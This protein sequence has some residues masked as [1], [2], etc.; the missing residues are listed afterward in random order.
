V[1][2]LVQALFVGLPG[3]AG[4]SEAREAQV[5]DIIVRE[6]A[7][8]LPLRNGIIPSKPPLYH[9]GAAALSL[10]L[11]EVSEFTARYTSQICAVICV[12]LVSL[13][14]YR[15]AQQRRSF[16]SPHHP[17][18][19]A[20]L[21]AAI[22][23]LTYGFYQMGCQA[24]VDMT[25][26]VC[27]WAAL[28]SVALSTRLGV[29]SPQQVSEVGRTL[30]WFCCALGVLARGPLGIA[31]PVALVGMAGWC[32]IGFVTTVR[33]FV[34]PSFGWFALAI[35]VVWYYRAYLVGGDA[36]L[37]RQLFFENIKRFSGGE[38]VNSQPWWFYV[39]SVLRTTLPWGI[40]L[41][42]IVVSSIF[43]QQTLSYPAGIVR[44]RWLP[45]ILLCTGIVLFSLS[46]GKRHSYLLP[47]LPLIAVQLGVEVS[48]LFEGGG[49]RARAR[50]VRVGRTTEVMLAGVSMFILF[51]IGVVGEFF[52]TPAGYL[53]DAYMAI[54]A[55]ISRSAILVVVCAIGT[56]LGLRRRLLTLYGSV[57]CLMIVLMTSAVAAGASIKAHLKSFDQ[58][59][60]AWLATASER[61][62]LAV[63]KH[64]FDEYFDPI[65]YYVHRPV[66]ILPFEAVSSE[67]EPA[68]VY[69]AKR[70]WLDAH[71]GV[72]RGS[73]VRVLTVRE[74]LLAHKNDASRDVVFFRCGTFGESS[75]GFESPRMHDVVDTLRNSG[76]DS[77]GVARFQM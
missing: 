38:F 23:S 15:F 44:R 34:R 61:D 75:G 6:G 22:L 9:W 47:L 49:D 32:S 70:Q 21:A 43:R 56:F 72:F 69:A 73:V 25:F 16:E 17:R 29:E 12:F 66:E 37:E 60:T 41:L 53:R 8:T 63:F 50:A 71:Q 5:V 45:L 1:Y 13:I 74:R 33:I 62:T 40:V 67:C 59:A 77:G 48:S 39:P 24:M 68:K 65:L 20:L 19:S 28:A 26:A 35:P 14:T 4:S 52:L 57:W 18:R 30:F 42:G 64:P 46:A 54:P 3:I 11:G 10:S 76:G 36:F 55:V 58:M 2:L 51:G 27:V 7:W 31:L